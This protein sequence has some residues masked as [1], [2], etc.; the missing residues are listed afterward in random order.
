M[1]SSQNH[2]PLASNRKTYFT[3]FKCFVATGILFL[4]SGFKNAGLVAGLVIISVSGFF[5][6]CGML[7]LLG[8][9]EN[10]NSREPSG[11]STPLLS[12]TASAVVSNALFPVKPKLINTYSKVG[13]LLF[14]WYGR[15]IIETSVLF[16]QVGFCCVYISFTGKS[17]KDALNSNDVFPE[18]KEWPLWLYMLLTIPIVAPLTYIRH[19]AFFSTPNLI[20][21]IFVVCSLGLMLGT[22]ID[23]IVNNS[24]MTDGHVVITNWT[25]TSDKEHSACLWIDTSSF[26]MFLGT[27]VYAFEGITMVIPIKNSMEHPEDLPKML[28][29]VIFTVTC[30]FALF[31]SLNFI[32]YGQETEAVIISN[33]PKTNQLVVTLM[34][35]VVAV[36]MF[37]LMIFPAA[38]I[39]EK[40][41]YKQERNSGKKWQK[42]FIRTNIVVLC[43]AIGIIGGDQVDKLVSVIGGAF[44]VPLALV[45]PPVLFLKSR[46][47]DSTFSNSL[48]PAGLALFGI[49]ASLL[50]T[51]TAI[52]Q[53]VKS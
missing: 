5:S 39:I 7:Y 14:G 35:V 9:I 53:M 28:L 30:L 44:C 45:Y 16:S 23:G 11:P 2:G 43:V 41:F 49:F 47:C 13:G 3:L 33:L 40:R 26:M 51:T 12:T 29:V 50:A 18:G 31:G 10:L 17:L 27:S 38:R 1:S 8:A 15:K 32:A 52:A 24:V 6:Y 48:V 4:P 21:N 20:A 36:F 42:N 22:A 34:F 46:S 25:C 37:P 19:L